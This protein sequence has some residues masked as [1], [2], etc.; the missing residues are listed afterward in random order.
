[1]SLCMP[2]KSDSSLDFLS[3]RLGSTACAMAL[4]ILPVALTTEL[5]LLQLTSLPYLDLRSQMGHDILL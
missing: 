3:R 2:L 4:R 5:H 1:M